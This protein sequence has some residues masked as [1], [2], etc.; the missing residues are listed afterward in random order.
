MY[1]FWGLMSSCT[2]PKGDMMYIFWGV[3]SSSHVLDEKYPQNVLSDV[4]TA[5][6]S[7]SELNLVIDVLLVIRD[8]RVIYAIV[9]GC[10]SHIT[11]FPYYF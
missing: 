8:T 5:L 1:I 9:P 7:V 4:S 3:M 11:P 2:N 6:A 10:T